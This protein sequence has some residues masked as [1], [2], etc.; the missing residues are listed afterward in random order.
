MEEAANACGMSKQQ[1]KVR[2]RILAPLLSSLSVACH[3][4]CSRNLTSKLNSLDMLKEELT[5]DLEGSA[6]DRL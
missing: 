3:D 5:L 2:M 4:L 6:N 1:M